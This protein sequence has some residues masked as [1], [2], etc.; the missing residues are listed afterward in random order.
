MKILAPVSNYESACYMIDAGA[1]EIY[2]G[3]DDTVF[4]KFL[5]YLR[6]IKKHNHECTKLIFKSIK[7]FDNKKLGVDK[8]YNPSWK[9]KK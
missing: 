2:L 3:M 4:E 5:I 9:I 6:I 7:D 1:K 8:I